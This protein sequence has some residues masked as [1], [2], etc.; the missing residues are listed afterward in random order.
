[1][2]TQMLRFCAWI[3]SDRDVFQWQIFQ[4]PCAGIEAIQTV[5]PSSNQNHLIKPWVERF[6]EFRKRLD[7]GILLRAH[8]FDSIAGARIFYI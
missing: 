2:S 8:S 3:L 5:R 4:F 1:M 6:D 7:C